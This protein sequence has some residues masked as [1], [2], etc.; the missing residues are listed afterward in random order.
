VL[1]EDAQ[2]TAL[3]EDRTGTWRDVDTGA[4]TKG[5]TDPY[6]RRYQKLVIE[7]G[8]KPADAT[9]AY[10]VLPAASVVGTIASVLA[11]RVRANTTTAQAVRLVDHTLLA[12]FYSAGTVDEVTV[13]GPASVALGRSG[14]SWSLAVSDPTQLQDSV[15]VTV[16]RT[17]VTVPLKGTFG[18]TKVVSLQ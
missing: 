10:A 5:T 7:H 6:A 11:W 15:E 3:R 2:V 12:N 16:R 8:V 1:L 4:N 14:G 18:A 9:Y 13:S 17:K